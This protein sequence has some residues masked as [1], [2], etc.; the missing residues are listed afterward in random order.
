MSLMVCRSCT[1]K[2]AVGLRMCPQCT[3]EDAYEEGTE[4]DMPK[5]TVHGGGTIEGTDGVTRQ[6][7]ADGRVADPIHEVD[8]N[9]AARVV[10]TDGNE[11]EPDADGLVTLPASAEVKDADP[12]TDPGTKPSVDNGGVLAPAK[13]T[14]PKKSTVTK[15]A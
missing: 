8:E 5:T 15:S 12:T 13:R 1:A 6:V 10:D 3:A 7:L 4:D 9:G 11:L 2:F 14:A